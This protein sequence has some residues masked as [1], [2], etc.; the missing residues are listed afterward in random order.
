MCRLCNVFE[1]ISTLQ[2]TFL[3]RKSV[4]FHSIR[5]KTYPQTQQKVIDSSCAV[6]LFMVSLSFYGWSFF[7]WSF[8]VGNIVRD[9]K[10]YRFFAIFLFA[11]I[12]SS[13]CNLYVCLRFFLLYHCFAGVTEL[14]P[15]LIHC[16]TNSI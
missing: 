14:Y 12:Q 13:C 3:K 6:F 4:F 15:I 8:H 1:N 11:L 2:L 7:L 10:C 16:K 9:N 5:S